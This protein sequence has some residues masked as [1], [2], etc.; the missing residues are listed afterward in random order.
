M[1]IFNHTF[2]SFRFSIYYSCYAMP[3]KGM[4]FDSL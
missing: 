2:Q 4:S 1:D 3:V